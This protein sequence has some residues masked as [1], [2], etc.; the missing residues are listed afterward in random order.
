MSASG[1]MRKVLDA[2]EGRVQT[3]MTQLEQVVNAHLGKSAADKKK[4]EA[5]KVEPIRSEES[6]GVAKKFL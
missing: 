6:A 2:G 4:P 5:V 3:F 1:E